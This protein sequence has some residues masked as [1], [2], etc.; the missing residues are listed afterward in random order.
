MV[1]IVWITAASLFGSNISKSFAGNYYRL[2]GLITFYGLIG[3]SV[4]VSYFWNDKFRKIVSQTFFA[5]STLLSIV[6][7]AEIATHEFGLGTAATFGNP[8]FLA[9][10]LAVSIPFTFYLFKST[11]YRIYLIGL[12]IQ[13]L[14]II[15]IGAVSSI[16][17]LIIFAFI[18]LTFFQKRIAKFLLIPLAVI[19]LL[20][21][22]FWSKNYFYIKDPRTLS[23]ESRERIFQNVI[24]GAVKKPVLGYGWANVDYAFNAGGWPIKFANDVYVDKA[25]SE[26]LE[27]F[28]TTGIPGLLIY[29]WFLLTFIIFLINGWKK[30]KEK[31]WSF[32]LLS[33]IILY[34]FHSQTNVISIMEQIVFWLVLG[35]T[36]SGSEENPTPQG[37]HGRRY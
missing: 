26:V 31:G 27:V 21:L 12:I 30:G 11:K 10:Y 35:I 4:L 23:Y 6:A 29:I 33:T 20:I 8:V 7:L 24:R 19:F 37:S 34:L 1:F 5:S 14:A 13:S 28:A 25:H 15:L 22:L 17:T 16:L 3:F 18:Y 2:D 9:G 36:L 32:T